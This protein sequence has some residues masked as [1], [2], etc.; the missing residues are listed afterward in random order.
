MGNT[1]RKNCISCWLLL[2]IL[3]SDAITNSIHLRSQYNLSIQDNFHL[4]H[5]SQYNVVHFICQYILIKP[6]SGLQ[7]NHMAAK[8]YSYFCSNT[9]CLLA[10]FHHMLTLW[11][12]QQLIWTVQGPSRTAS[13]IQIIQNKTISKKLEKKLYSWIKWTWL[14][15]WFK[16]NTSSWWGNSG[17]RTSKQHLFDT[18]KYQRDKKC[19]QNNHWWRNKFAF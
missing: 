17:K 6:N 13:F 2:D 19:V 9:V 11:A 10:W 1:K 4:F 7:L 14:C 5:Y 18:W 8:L 12:Y 16:K 15:A 3:H